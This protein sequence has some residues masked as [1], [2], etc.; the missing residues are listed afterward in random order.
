MHGL[1]LLISSQHRGAHD[2]NYRPKGCNLSMYEDVKIRS[3]LSVKLLS[4]LQLI[5]V[6]PET[7]RLKIEGYLARKWGLM[8]TMFTAS[9]PYYPTDPF[10]QPL[11]R[12]VRMQR[13]LLLGRQ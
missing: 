12:V 5:E 4:L 1:M 7:E 2:S 8:S 11:R 6:V 3:N 9:H 10:N 13:Y